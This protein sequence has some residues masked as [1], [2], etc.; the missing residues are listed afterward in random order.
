MLFCF[1]VD[2]MSTNFSCFRVRQL[3][4]ACIVFSEKIGIIEYLHST[5]VFWIYCFYLL[6]VTTAKITKRKAETRNFYEFSWNTYK[7]WVEHAPSKT[8]QSQSPQSPVKC[9]KYVLSPTTHDTLEKNFEIIF[10]L[11]LLS[12]SLLVKGFFLL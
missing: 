9:H 10:L 11:H 12:E 5:T 2:E 1:Q 4:S 6:L 7:E 3:Y 8:R